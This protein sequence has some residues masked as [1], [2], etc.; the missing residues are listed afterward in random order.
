MERLILITPRLV[1]PGRTNVPARVDEPGFQQK[2]TQNHFELIPLEEAEK[3]RE[4]TESSA[5][6]RGRK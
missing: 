2:A 5:A 3:A 4:E 6:E 1:T